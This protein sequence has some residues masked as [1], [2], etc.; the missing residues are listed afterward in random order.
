MLKRMNYTLHIHNYVGQCDVSKLNK[1]LDGVAVA[2]QRQKEKVCRSFLF[3]LVRSCCRIVVGTDSASHLRDSQEAK[4]AA[5][6]EGTGG[7][8]LPPATKPRR[9]RRITANSTAVIEIEAELP[10]C[11][12]RFAD[13]AVGHL[14]C[15]QPSTPIK[16]DA[17]SCLPHFLLLLAHLRVLRVGSQPL[18]RFLLRDK[19]VTVA[20]GKI[21]KILEVKPSILDR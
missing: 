9:P 6:N 4:I 10:V 12:E 19:G 7:G 8:A 11:C 21:L 13:L 20:V 18:G 15:F 17:R 14:G 16:I 3:V 2:I 5:T 1:L